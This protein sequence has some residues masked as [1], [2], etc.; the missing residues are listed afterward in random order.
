MFSLL[1]LPG[2]GIGPEVMTEVK[3]VISWFQDKRNLKIDIEEGLVGGASYDKHGVPLTEEILNKALG[4]DA[5]L[6]GAVGGPNYDNL[7]FDLKPERA[8]LRLRKELDLF[9][10]IRPAQCFDALASFSS[11]KKEIVSGLDIVIVRELTS[12]IYFGEPRGIHTDGSN[13]RV[14]VNTQRYTESEIR[15]VAISAFE[16]ALK[17]NKKLCSMEKANV[18]ESGVLWRDVV[19][20]V[21]VDYQDVEL[22]LSLIHI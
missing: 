18:M 12:G 16:L 4:V 15:R 1:I 17:R 2:D 21:H 5:V 11:L 22:S 8:L 13:E 7:S 9:A 14:G 10:N 6:L 20:E 3:R 19:N